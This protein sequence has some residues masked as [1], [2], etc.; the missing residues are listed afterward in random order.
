MQ[1]RRILYGVMGEGLGHAMRARV[2][3]DE[4]QAQGHIVLAAS[5]SKATL[6]LRTHGIPVVDVDGL[7]LVT[8][9]GAVLRARTVRENLAAT[10]RRLKT[11]AGIPWQTVQAF[12]PDVVVSD[13]ESFSHAVGRSLGVPVIT[14]DH[15]HIMSVANHTAVLNHRPSSSVAMARAFVHAKLPGCRHHIV[16]TFFFAPLKKRH[17][18]TTTLT[19]PILRPAW[20]S[21]R[22]LPG[23]HVVVYQ[24]AR[25]DSSLLRALAGVPDV[26]FRVY[27]AGVGQFAANVV[28]C[29]FSEAG[30][31]EDMRLSRAVLAN[32]GFTGIAE[33][34]VL[35][36][37]VLSVPLQH[38][39]EQAL[40]ALWL[41]E[42]GHGRAADR[43]T[44]DVV[45]GFLDAVA[46]ARFR[47]PDDDEDARLRSGTKDALAALNGQLE[48]LA[49]RSVA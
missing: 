13:F 6:L 49:L 47:V 28:G 3:I 42:L 2:M 48:R 5:S 20:T 16:P 26:S 39:G 24:T 11:A 25:G 35:R 41:E 7:H 29:R 10:P 43:W 36:K 21:A 19:G 34:I 33:A 45:K 30:F 17:R 38:Q 8:R 12:E 18:T 22:S 31:L 40:N 44:P 27:G 9:E 37:P 23:D 14:L 1:T 46:G 32:G 4:L 15:Q